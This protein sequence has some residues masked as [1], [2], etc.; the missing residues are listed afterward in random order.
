MSV[1]EQ[2][3]SFMINIEPSEYLGRLQNIQLTKIG[4]RMSSDDSK[5]DIYQ[6]CVLRVKCET[7]GSLLLCKLTGL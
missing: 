2:I 4:V 1:P 6:K 7:R 3:D 5:K